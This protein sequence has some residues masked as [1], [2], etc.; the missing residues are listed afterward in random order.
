MGRP[1]IAVLTVSLA[2]RDLRFLRAGSSEGEE[3][4]GGREKTRSIGTI[5]YQIIDF[6][7]NFL[8]DERQEK[9]NTNRGKERGGRGKTNQGREQK[10][11]SW[12]PRD[13]SSTQGLCYQSIPR[14]MVRILQ[15]WRPGS[16]GGGP[17]EWC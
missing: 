17:E 9:G 8:L 11:L 13:V 10:L 16:G 1:G 2:Q 6:S 5:N 7:A 3:G 12:P 15:L 14:R 4:G